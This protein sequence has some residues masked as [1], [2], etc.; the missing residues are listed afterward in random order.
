MPSN[1]L[2]IDALTPTIGAEVSG[3]DLTEP[4]DDD[5]VEDIHQAMLRHQVLFFRDQALD[6]DTLSTFGLRFGAPHTHPSHPDE[7]GYRGIM[8]LHTDAQ[9]KTYGGRKWH[10]DVTCDVAP[11]MA[12]ILHLHQVPETGGDTLFGN[13]VAA[14]E[15][16]SPT[17]Q[18]ML[19][20]LTALHT[21]KANFLGYYGSKDDDLRDGDY[22]EAEHPVI[23]TH[24]ETGRKALFVNEIFTSHM[25]G[26]E[27]ELSRQLLDF[28]YGHIREPRFQCRF[29]WRPNSVAFWDNRSTQHLA[30]WD[31]FPETRSGHRFTVRGDRPI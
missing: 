15:A 8:K 31:Y 6:L 14:Y 27:P 4:L 29:R 13:M 5:T 26:L 2:R 12:S 22:P 28:L 18:A 23:R 20:N 17:L 10:S 11:P 7:P 16:L 30:M 19:A 24:P 9:S 3:V 25:I 1:S 21:S